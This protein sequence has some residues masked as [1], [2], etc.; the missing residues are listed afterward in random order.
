MNSDKMEFVSISTVY[1]KNNGDMILETSPTMTLTPN[2]IAVKYHCIRHNYGKEFVIRKI[3]S[4]N[5]KADIFTKG[6]QGE[7]FSRIRKFP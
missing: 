7:L 1:E 5:Q 3:Y 4:E 2:H 6:L